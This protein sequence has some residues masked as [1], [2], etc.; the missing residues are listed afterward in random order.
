MDSKSINALCAQ[1][2]KDCK[3]TAVVRVVSCPMF[4]KK[5]EENE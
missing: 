5:E 2:V 3:Q 4:E 1:C